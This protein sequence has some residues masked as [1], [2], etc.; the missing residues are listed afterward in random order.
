MPFLLWLEYFWHFLQATLSWN[1]FLKWNLC[2]SV[3][4]FAPV[5]CF[6]LTLFIWFSLFSVACM[7]ALD[8]FGECLALV[9]SHLTN[10]LVDPDKSVSQEMTADL[11]ILRA[12]IHAKF[13]NVSCT[14]TKHWWL[15][16]MYLVLLLMTILVHFTRCFDL[17]DWIEDSFLQQAWT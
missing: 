4:F 13:G 17:K 2:L 16:L 9:S 15:N 1:I 12:R 8:R 10:R 5:H 3:Y 6:S 11:Y 7:A 14:H